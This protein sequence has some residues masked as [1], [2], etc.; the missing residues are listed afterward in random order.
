MKKRRRIWQPFIA[1]LSL[2]TL[3]LSFSLTVKAESPFETFSVDGY[4]RTIVTQP[5]YEPEGVMA[6]DIYITDSNGERVYSPLNKP[7]DLFIDQNDGIYIADT[8]NNRIVQLDKNGKLVR[9]LTVLESPLNQPSGVFITEN[10]DIYIADTGNKRV[11]RLNKEGKMIQEFLRPTSKFI[12]KKFVY[13]PINMVVDRRGFVYV[14]SSGTYQGII[15][16]YPNGEFYGFYG[17]NV[18]EVSFMDR[19]RKMFYTKEQLARQVRLLPNAIRNIDIDKNG[20]VY[21]VSRD[22]TKEMKKLNVRG[23]NQWKDFSFTKNVKTDFLREEATAATSSEANVTGVTSVDTD[24]TDIT[25]NENG[26]VTVADKAN[27]LVAQ[28]NQNGEL[29]FFWGAPVTSGSPQVGLNKSPVALDTNSENKIFILD[30]SLNLIQV[31][32]PTQ[33]GNTVQDAF[34]LTQQGKYSESEKYWREIVKQNALFTPAYAGLARASFYQEDYKKS[35]EL[36]KLAGDDQ[37]YSDSFWQLRLQ[38]FQ[39]NFVYLANAFLI[40]GVAFLVIAQFRKRN[41]KRTSGDGDVPKEK[42]KWMKD[43]KLLNQLK[44]AFYIL[45]HPLDG[46]A[47]IRYRSMGGYTSA[48][49]ILLLVIAVVIA[50]TYFTSFTFQ[51]V[52][53]GSINISSILTISA[54]VWISWVICHYLIGSIKQGQARFKDVFVGSAYALFPVFLLGLPLALLSNLMSL[55]ESS[56]Y[57]FFSMLMIIWS[58][59]LFF[60]MIQSL[61]NYSV[62]ETIINGLLSL[63][64]MIMLWVLVFIVVGLSSETIDFILTLYRE[65]TM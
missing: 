30:D 1:S 32:V 8:G 41:S 47:D 55:N 2:V 37:G 62:G 20:Y 16:F 23:E 14:V 54:T 27:A 59:A 7:Q 34:I 21:T 28:F 6:Q 64:S 48:I 46:F 60:W 57:G 61:Q 33:F 50:R 17:T 11:V 36:Y 4:G 58:F 9:I 26:I 63:F 35:Q 18:S 5:A 31:L 29:L 15:Q 13:E 39:K 25:V 65:V 56:I 45:R 51:P 10:G 38:W 3:F 42:S 19:I 44:H 43:I 24:L 53:V 22:Q 49:I 40:F 52:P 12:D